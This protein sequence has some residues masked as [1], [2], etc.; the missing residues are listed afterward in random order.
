MELYCS[1]K[2]PL[3]EQ[4][5]W[6]ELTPGQTAGGGGK[7]GQEISEQVLWPLR[8]GSDWILKDTGQRVTLIQKMHKT[9]KLNYKKMI[10]I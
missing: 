6:A 8:E 9:Q 2:V 3:P 7:G 4:R 10:L 5:S 1:K